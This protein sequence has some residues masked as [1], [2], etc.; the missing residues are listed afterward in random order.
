MRPSVDQLEVEH[1]REHRDFV[2]VQL[3]QY[4]KDVPVFRGGYK[5]AMT[6]DG[7]LRMISGEFFPDIDVRVTPALS[8]AQA[9]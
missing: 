9:K 8:P 4:Y 2:Y 6:D 5:V 1:T 3:K 7:S